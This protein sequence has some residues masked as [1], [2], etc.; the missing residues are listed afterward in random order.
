MLADRKAQLWV[1]ENH[2]IVVP[3]TSYV[4]FSSRFCTT[5]D[6]PTSLRCFLVIPRRARC[7]D[8]AIKQRG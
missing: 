1:Y 8:R 6:D 4:N 2:N 7:L 3:R 5:I